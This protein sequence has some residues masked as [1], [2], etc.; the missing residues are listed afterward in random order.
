MSSSKIVNVYRFHI[1]EY[2]YIGQCCAQTDPMHPDRILMPSD[3]TDI[4]P[5]TCKSDQIP[6][7]DINS[8]VWTV[9]SRTKFKIPS[10]ENIVFRVLFDNKDGIPTLKT[11]CIDPRLFSKH[12]LTSKILKKLTQDISSP[13][14]YF[15]NPLL[16]FMDIYF[17]LTILNQ[18]IISYFNYLQYLFG[19]NRTDYI[20]EEISFLNIHF[21]EIVHNLKRIL[22][23][24]VCLYFLK[25][26]PS[27]TKD[28]IFKLEVDGLGRLENEKFKNKAMPQVINKI[29]KSL[30]YGKY[31]PYFRLVNMLDNSFKHHITYISTNVYIKDDYFMFPFCKQN[32]LEEVKH[33]YVIPQDFVSAL[34]S[35]LLEFC[36]VEINGLKY[37]LEPISQL[38]NRKIF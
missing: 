28:E 37:S 23:Q 18:K 10:I 33:L 1:K 12:I 31:E 38:L 24:I 14:C 36:D 32:D 5:P 8:N 13:N 15:V 35:F 25:Y 19:T 17:R 9:E 29:K 27:I 30:N 7:F 11:S 4:K 16:V 34:N 6:V 3:C 22:D 21:E 20:I 26:A 2:Y